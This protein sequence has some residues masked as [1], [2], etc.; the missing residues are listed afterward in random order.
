MGAFSPTSAAA[1]GAGTAWTNVVGVEGVS[2]GY[3]QVV[4]SNSSSNFLVATNFNFTVPAATGPIIS[5]GLTCLAYCNTSGSNVNPNVTAQLTLAGTAFGSVQELEMA[6]LPEFYFPTRAITLQVSNLLYPSTNTSATVNSASFGVQFQATAAGTAPTTVYISNVQ[7]TVSWLSGANTTVYYA[8]KYG[9]WERGA[10]KS[11]ASFRLEA[12][13]MDLRAL[14]PETVLYPG[15][16]T[17]LMQVIN[18]GMLSGAKVIIKSLFWPIGS[19]YITGLSMGTLTLTVGQIGNVKK[20]G[21]SNVVCEVFD[22]TYTLVS[23]CPPFQIQSS[24]RHSL[25][26]PSCTLLA[27]NF[28]SAIQTVHSGSTNLN[29]NV[30]IAARANSTGYAQFSLVLI[31]GIIYMVTNVGG[32]VTAGSA[33][34]FNTAQG[35]TTNDGSV[36]WTSM[37]GS[38]LLGYILYDTGQNTGLKFSIKQLVA[39]SGYVQLQLIKPTPFTVSTGDTLQLVPGCDKTFGTCLNVYN[40]LIHFGGMP[41]VP[42]PEQAA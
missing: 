8:S 16:T 37:N 1:T 34:S 25:F 17:P 2:N 35:A 33:P 27:A 29:I 3:A 7:L 42:N 30:T 40:N 19:S 32:G 36:V 10:V 13:S 38:Y 9:T 18:V 12:K 26:D 5:V 22:I 21:R 20:T 39:F 14:I 15:T 24:C 28:T 31:S 23:P 41:F 6:G 4:L 11:E